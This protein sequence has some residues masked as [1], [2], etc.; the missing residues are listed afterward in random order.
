M[1]TNKLLIDNIQFGKSLTPYQSRSV[2]TDFEDI[3]QQLTLDLKAAQLQTAVDMVSSS[4]STSGKKK[5]DPFGA[6]QLLNMDPL[7]FSLLEEMLLM[8]LEEQKLATKSA[9]IEAQTG[10]KSLE[11]Q[12][13]DR[14]KFNLSK[15]GGLV[16]KLA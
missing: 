3:L 5:N 15:V 1:N 13:N 8:A 12:V 14:Y 10:Q 7:E 9:A 4:N 6:T 2:G 11:S 16:K